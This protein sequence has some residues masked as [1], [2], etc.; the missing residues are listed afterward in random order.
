VSDA[1]NAALIGPHSCDN[2]A[3]RP[4]SSNLEADSSSSRPLVQRQRFCCSYARAIA[5]HVAVFLSSSCCFLIRIALGC[6]AMRI[7]GITAAA[8]LASIAEA[9]TLTPPVLPLI[10]RNPY[11]S[12]WLG[13]ARDEPWQKWPMF[14][15]G[16]EVRLGWLRM[17]TPFLW[18][19]EFWVTLT[20]DVPRRLD[21]ESSHIFLIL[22]KSS[23]CWAGPRTR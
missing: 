13:N 9:S 23:R 2:P 3:T 17:A 21:S 15:T 18:L 7:S 4:R 6:D 20:D 16:S 12:T 11:L 22:K 10:V 5:S 19:K 8:L 14:W 1:R